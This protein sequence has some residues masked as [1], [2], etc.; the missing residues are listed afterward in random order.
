M[1][2][3]K[4]FKHSRQSRQI[5][6]RKSFVFQYMHFL[7]CHKVYSI[8]AIYVLVHQRKI[9]IK[10]REY[11]FVCRLQRF[12]Y[13][14]LNTRQKKIIINSSKFLELQGNIL[15]WVLLKLLQL[16]ISCFNT[17]ADPSFYHIKTCLLKAVDLL[18]PQSISR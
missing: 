10:L 11:E 12:F 5:F 7:C 18:Q 14:Q 8:I 15:V 4:C 16:L 9:H 6:I 2:I 13:W 3:L 1:W 17:M